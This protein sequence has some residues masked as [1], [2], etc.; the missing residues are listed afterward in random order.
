MFVDRSLAE[1]LIRLHSRIRRDSLSQWFTSLHTG[2][3]RLWAT[4]HAGA[5][6]VPVA[7]AR[8]R[9][10]RGWLAEL[11]INAWIYDLRSPGRSRG[12]PYGLAHERGDWYRCGRLP[13]FALVGPA[14]PAVS[15]PMQET[16]GAGKLIL[17]DATAAPISG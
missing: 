2:A 8:L 6:A 5:I 14:S 11:P 3:R 12:L 4:R 7:F 15:A 9:E 1:F 10:L 17:K 16:L 13:V